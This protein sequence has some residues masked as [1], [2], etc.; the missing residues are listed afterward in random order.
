MQ[1]TKL[2][3]FAVLALF[4]LAFAFAM[5][6]VAQT[7]AD[8]PVTFSL[9]K[10]GVKTFFAE[11]KK[12]TGLDFIC[13]SE[14]VRQLPLVTVN[15]KD[16]PAKR[17][18][19]DV[20]T[21][22][23]CKF[24]IDGSIVTITHRDRSGRI[25]RIQGM[26]RDDQ[27]EPLL[28]AIVR[29]KDG[30]EQV[31]TDMDGH[32]VI[33][34][35]TGACQLEYAYLGMLTHTADFAQGTADLRQNVRLVSDNRLGEVVVTGY[36]TI[37][38]ER[39]TGSYSIVKKDDIQKRHTS[40]LSKALEGLVAG[41]QGNDDGRGGKTFTIRGV[42]TMNADTQPLI[43]I[44]GF[45]IMD[46]P[47]EGAKS[48]PNMSAME[49]INTDDIES[50]TFLKDAAAASI[51]GARSANGVIVITTKK[52]RKGEKKW[53]IEASTQLSIAKKQDVAHLTD[54]ATSQQMIN[55]QRWMF[56][57]DMVSGGYTR[58]MDN[59]YRSMTQSELAFYQGMN[60]G[61]IS[62]E[63]MNRQLSAYAALSNRQQ[64]KDNLLKSPIQSKTNVALSGG[65]GNWGTR[66][67]AEFTHDEGDF[68][69]SRDNTWK[70]DWQNDYRLN[71]HIAFSLGLNL[72]NANRHSSVMSLSNIAELSPYEML[73]N[74]DGSYAS[75]FHSSYNSDVLL[76]MF[77]W[78]GFSYKNM[79]YNLL[80]EANTRQQRTTNTALRTQVSMQIDIIDGLRFNSRFQYESSRYKRRQTNSEE[81][82][83]TRY[84]VNYYTPG[85]LSGTALGQSALPKGSIIVNG[86]GRNYSSLFRNDI[87][88][89]RV[90][91]EKHAIN[92]VVGNEIS[93]Y[94][95]E[96]W[97]NPYLFGVTAN[98]EGQV[99]QTG[100]FDTMDAS[101]S[102][103]SGVPA[104]GKEHVVDS[105]NHNRFVSFYGNA[106]YMYDE[107]YGLSVSARSDASNLITSEAKY[108]W[109]P[110]WSIGAMW[111]IANESWLKE[112]DLVNRLTLRLT[113]GQNGNAATTSSAR[114]T[115][116]TE[117]S[118]PDEW[119][120]VYPGSIYDYG[121]PTLRWE[122]T[123][124]TNVG[125][126]FSLFNNHLFGS[127]DYYYKKS[128]DVL[129]QVAIAGVNGTTYAT[130][131][132]AE[133]LNKG[134]ELTLGANGTFGDFSV[135]GT[136]T[137]AYN[138]N[139]IT[140]LYTE[141]SNL[142]DFLN[143]VYI[144]DYPISPMFT[145][146]YGGVK[147]GVPTLLDTE[148][149]HYDLNDFSIYYLPWQQV[150]HYQGTAIAPHTAGLNLTVG[151]KSLTLSAFVNGRFGHKMT[152]PQ[153]TYD[154]ISEWSPKTNVQA[155]IAELM[156]A[157]GKVITN[158]SG[159][160][161]L[162]TVDDEGNPVG[163]MQYNAWSMYR[164]SL[165]ITTEDASYIY[166]SEID[167]NYQLPRK[168]LG[169]GWVK[170]VS[171]FGKVEN[172]GLLWTA[173]SKGYHPE[174]LPG[175]YCPQPTFSF[176][177][178]VRL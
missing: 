154:Y 73:L 23:G 7:A 79:N 76:S 54:L 3:R 49:R 171:I 5:P 44:D 48:N 156:D 147:N 69:G 144:P 30:S 64:I 94:H 89:D 111:N 102:T 39:A 175:S 33:N 169:N 95:Y 178:S 124:I 96:S 86:R 27:G 140:K 32:Y 31:V 126:D 141:A 9:Q 128:T 63:E 71:K 58:N 135:S 137:Y 159:H 11:M 103:I 153:F 19:S 14:L 81:S 120:G 13:S 113:Y 117:S 152:M 93:N 52:G 104:Q 66:F 118:Y 45:P 148:G 177:A 61:T 51:W 24:T 80:Q 172:V 38:K 6:S 2:R 8:K 46:N 37:S 131:N 91:A 35:P 142:S 20:L 47:S 138:K 62:T 162:P 17:V 36:Q 12:Q 109:S 167:L 166:L 168:W 106:S 74:E 85:D 59:L 55:Y 108:R 56:E 42:N 161:P 127:V 143:S 176:G 57:K 174:Y 88:F 29:V 164:N 10:A 155:E 100:Y 84:Q 132:N 4:S 53:N 119:T 22:L 78:S 136:L 77:D 97:T 125:L 115:I 75:N 21:Q 110:L 25:R 26:V 72:M 145:F 107:R 149:T 134:L 173:N 60:W 92:A 65:I 18:L 1:K 116:K 70:L 67:S 133:M 123:A 163:L 82:F 112:S 160:L 129:G 98:S 122:K 90:L 83:Y 165:D 114:T 99:G 43:V 87:T 121:N 40:S 151:W 157:S 146:E 139:K 16:V 50:I 105:W 34:A 130:F 158:P 28:G 170:D 101:Q 15:V 150:L 41:M 68:I